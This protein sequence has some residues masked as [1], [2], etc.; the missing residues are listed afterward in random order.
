MS[1]SGVG[2]PTLAVERDIAGPPPHGDKTVGPGVHGVG[3]VRR[4]VDR[5]ARRK[6]QAA[7]SRLPLGGARKKRIGLGRLMRM[8]GVVAVGGLVEEAEEQAAAH[9]WRE[10]RVPSLSVQV[11]GILEE[12][13][14]DEICAQ[15]V[16]NHLDELIYLLSS[17]LIQTLN[18][19]IYS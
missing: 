17:L 10:L 13:A 18:D 4:V 2:E 15:F 1:G 14:V 9:V 16:H 6:G 5:L 7:V 3:E 11:E 19:H 12:H 8:E